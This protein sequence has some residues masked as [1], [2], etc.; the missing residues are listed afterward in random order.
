MSEEEIQAVAPESAKQAYVVEPQAVQLTVKVLA[1][2]ALGY[3][4][5]KERDQ[6][7][8]YYSQLQVQNIEAPSD[9]GQDKQP[10]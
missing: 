4:A 8:D 2:V 10:G 6:L 3:P 7:V 5:S 1:G 9:D